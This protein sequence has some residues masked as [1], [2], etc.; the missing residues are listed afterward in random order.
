METQS[1]FGVCFLI[2]RCKTDK[3]RADIYVRIT[4]D[5]NAKEFSL[6]EQID[7]VNSENTG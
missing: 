3:K 1:S 5:G 7:I 4:V 2:R 6:K